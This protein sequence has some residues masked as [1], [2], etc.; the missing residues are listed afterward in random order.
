MIQGSLNEV[1]FV[2]CVGNDNFAQMLKEVTLKDN[3]NPVF[4]LN[5]E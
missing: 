3:V 1:K 4:D 2:G 5:N